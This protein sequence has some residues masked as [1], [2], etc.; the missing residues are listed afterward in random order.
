MSKVKLH[1]S[2]SK[3]QLEQE[4]LRFCC[5]EALKKIEIVEPLEYQQGLVWTSS[6]LKYR[7]QNPLH[8]DIFFNFDEYFSKWKSQ[9]LSRSKSLLLKS[10]KGDRK[11]LDGTCGTGKDCSQLLYFGCQVSAYERN[12]SVYLLLLSA[13]HL[14]TNPLVKQLKLF[15]GDVFEL[16]QIK[17]HDVEVF[18]FDPMFSHEKSIKSLPR[19][20]MQVFHYLVGENPDASEAKKLSEALSFAP[21]VL[22]KRAIKQQ[23]LWQA[24]DYQYLGKTTRLD[25]YKR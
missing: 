25:A 24:V 13:I 20:E 23:P 14:S 8:N 12:I 15:F 22:V 7:P 16:A 4:L 18:Y 5:P 10:L 17:K 11:I 2:G 1:L 6:G 21:K 3:N 19:K 9:G